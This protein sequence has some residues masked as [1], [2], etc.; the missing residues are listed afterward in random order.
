MA[1]KKRKGLGFKAR[2]QEWL[3]ER[4]LT[5][6]KLAKLSGID[7]ATLSKL[8]KGNRE[9]T[10]DQAFALSRTMGIPVGQFLVE[11]G[12]EKLMTGWVPVAELE[13]LQNEHL[14]VVRAASSH[15]ASARAAHKEL[16]LLT[17]QANKLSAEVQT[18]KAR[19]KANSEQLAGAAECQS[20]L[21]Q[22]ESQIERLERA[23]RLA[24][25]RS[26]DLE[27]QLANSNRLVQHNHR[28]SAERDRII[29]RLKVQL[30]DA[31]NSK[32]ATAWVSALLGGVAVAVVAGALSADRD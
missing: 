11:T 29:E 15:E 18:V 27:H 8:A 12:L 5:Q 2:L 10:L 7:P 3:T 16:E 9:P 1:T 4:E 32:T 21:R 20:K 17:E 6:A 25:A 22:A 30:A 14:E 24:E 31:T 28:C 26:A 23:V 13:K 19:E